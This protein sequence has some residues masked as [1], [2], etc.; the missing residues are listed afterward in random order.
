MTFQVREVRIRNIIVGV[1]REALRTTEAPGVVLGESGPEGALLTR[2]L[3]EE[4]ISLQ[5]PS[6]EAIQLS[7]EILTPSY[8]EDPEARPRRYSSPIGLAA[9][10]LAERKGLLLLGT[11][12]KTMLLLSPS[13]PWEQ[14]LPL[15][16]VFASELLDL[17]GE[18][19]I[20]PVLDGVD[21]QTLRAVDDGL[22]SYLENGIGIQDALVTVTQPLRDEVAEALALARRGWHPHPLVPKLRS[23]TLGIDLDF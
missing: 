21:V 11:A 6:Q 23:H 9:R 13:P 8:R 18:C 2:W 14:I 20:P 19:T 22:Q 16:D 15:G 17:E 4:G 12:T 7:R 3:Q 10:A 1:M 5:T